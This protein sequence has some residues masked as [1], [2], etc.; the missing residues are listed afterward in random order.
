M[1]APRE[2]RKAGTY[3]TV[4]IPAVLYPVAVKVN[5][6]PWRFHDNAAP[7]LRIRGRLGPERLERF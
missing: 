5:G 6:P 2:C 7:R 1:R 3:V 4:G